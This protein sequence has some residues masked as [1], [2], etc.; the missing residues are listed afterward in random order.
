MGAN[1]SI[2]LPASAR[3]LHWA[4]CIV[5]TGLVL[6]FSVFFFGEGPPP[7]NFGTAAL[8]VMLAGFVLGWWNDLAG[9]LVAL[10]GI[11]LFFLWNYSQSGRFPGGPVFP[12][13]FIPG[14]MYLA[15]WLRRCYPWQ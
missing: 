15:S 8:V 10:L 9:G 14:V 3:V 2:A 6:L 4:G 12:L 13:C 11:S 5:G 7:L 1:S